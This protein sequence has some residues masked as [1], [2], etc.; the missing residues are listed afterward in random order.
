LPGGVGVE[1][2]LPTQFLHQGLLLNPGFAG[3]MITFKTGIEEKTPVTFFPK[4]GK[5]LVLR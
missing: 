5:S 4:P 2:A 3:L 1:C